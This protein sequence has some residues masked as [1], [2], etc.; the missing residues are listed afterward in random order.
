M[1]LL[2]E[3]VRDRRS[4]VAFRAGERARLNGQISVLFLQVRRKWPDGDRHPFNE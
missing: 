1:P 4:T 3:V 2:Q